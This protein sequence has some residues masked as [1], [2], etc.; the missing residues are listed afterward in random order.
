VRT[1][2]AYAWLAAERG[3]GYGSRARV[4]EARLL[5]WDGLASEA[6][7][8][9]EPVVARRHPQVA[10]LLDALTRHGARPARMS[11]SGS[12]VFGVMTSEDPRAAAALASLDARLI[13]T[14]TADRVEQVQV[15]D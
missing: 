5:A 13:R 11:G 2:D 10:A 1:A 6:G 9:F 7:N 15:L 12:A 4:L 14:R 8:D 3:E